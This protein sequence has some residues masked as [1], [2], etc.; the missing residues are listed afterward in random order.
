MMKKLEWLASIT[1]VAAMVSLAGCAEESDEEAAS[2]ATGRL[3]YKDAA[4]RS[5]GSPHR[6]E[7]PPGQE[8]ELDMRVAG[9]GTLSGLETPECT[10]D[11]LAGNFTGLFTGTAD[12]SDDGAYVAAFAESSARFSTPTASCEIPSV[13][14]ETLTQVV[15]VA[16]LENTSQNCQTYCQAKARR[17]AES[18]CRVSTDAASCRAQAEAEYAASCQTQCTG[19]TTRRITAE[20]VIDATTDAALLAELNARQLGVNGMGTVEADLTFEQIREDDGDGAL[21]PESP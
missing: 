18:E 1:F 13:S 15:L 11:G 2:S 4:T 16:K 7:S 6:P 10:A 9:S 19:S 14:I 17:V 5:D 8:I 3:A 12:V 20:L 21:V